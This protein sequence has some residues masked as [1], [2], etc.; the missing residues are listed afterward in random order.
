MH[1]SQVSKDQNKYNK[2]KKKELL[3]KT[4]NT[5]SAKIIFKKLRDDAFYF[6]FFVHK[7]LCYKPTTLTKKA[8]PKVEPCASP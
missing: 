6:Y 1:K 8:S 4:Q 5:T 7:D 2:A 3:H